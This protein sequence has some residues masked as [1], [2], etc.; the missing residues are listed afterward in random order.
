MKFSATLFIAALALFATASEAGHGHQ[1]ARHHN[2]HPRHHHRR[3]RH[4][5]HHAAHPVAHPAAAHARAVILP[6][7]V[8]AASFLANRPDGSGV[9]FSSC[10]VPGSTIT[11]NSL[12]FS[13][14]PP[15][16][17]NP[18]S[19]IA[20]ATLTKTLEQGATLEVVGTLGSMEVYRGSYDM[21]AESA[22]SG[23]MCPIPVGD[24]KLSTTVALPGNV[25]P[26]VGIDIVATAKNADGSDLFCLK[27]QLKFTP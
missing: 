10:S 26:F 4:P 27:T 22:K 24:N 9:Q 2:R 12:D 21:C 15:S 23:V 14:N 25:P 19:I 1:P 13:P 17:Q 8:H 20:S 7:E 3:P 18:V 11:V 6:S 16:L 5:V